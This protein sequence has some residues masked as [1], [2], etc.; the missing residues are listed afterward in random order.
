MFTVCMIADEIESGGER[1]YSSSQSDDVEQM[2][3]SPMIDFLLLSRQACRSSRFFPLS[4]CLTNLFSLGLDVALV[5]TICF[6]LIPYLVSILVV[7]E[8]K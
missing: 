2:K 1:N 8:A 5:I 3:V 7:N 4:S 6:C